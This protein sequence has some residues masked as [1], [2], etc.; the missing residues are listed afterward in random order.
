MEQASENGGQAQKN[1]VGVRITT[2]HAVNYGEIIRIVGSGS[3]LGDWNPEQG[4]GTGYLLLLDVSAFLPQSCM[5]NPLAVT[6]FPVRAS[7]PMPL[8]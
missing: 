4:A 2:Q 5:D 8:H 1:L 3:A 7:G 6:E